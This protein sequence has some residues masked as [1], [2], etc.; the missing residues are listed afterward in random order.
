MT[1]TIQPTSYS[2]FPI[3]VAKLK[4]LSDQEK[5]AAAVIRQFKKELEEEI[6]PYTMRQK[7]I[8]QEIGV[9]REQLAPMVAANYAASGNKTFGGVQYRESWAVDVAPE[10]EELL[11]AELYEQE[12]GDQPLVEVRLSFNNK[13]VLAWARAK[14]A[15]GQELPEGMFLSQNGTVA[16]V[17]DKD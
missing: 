3:L 12:W 4:Q 2:E 17:G 10:R 13:A 9:V 7:E 6:S 5:S 11:L 15:L 1:D 14:A 16:L 8:K